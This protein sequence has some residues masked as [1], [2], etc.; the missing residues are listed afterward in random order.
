MNH[1][2]ASRAV[3]KIVIPK[4]DAASPAFFNRIEECG[5]SPAFFNPIEECGAS[6][7][8]FIS[9][10]SGIKSARRCRAL[11]VF[12]PKNYFSG[13]RSIR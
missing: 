9:R 10:E 5:A 4:N 7:E 8:V 6:C 13:F 11:I 3:S 12:F 2:A 1:R